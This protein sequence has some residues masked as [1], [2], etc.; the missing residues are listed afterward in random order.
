MFFKEWKLTSTDNGLKASSSR[1]GGSAEFRSP[2]L[3]VLSRPVH[4]SPY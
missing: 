1:K 2:T 4:M 3:L